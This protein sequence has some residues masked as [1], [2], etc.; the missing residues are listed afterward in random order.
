MEEEQS[1]TAA[2]CFGSRPSCL[3]SPYGVIMDSAI[4]ILFCSLRNMER[5]LFIKFSRECQEQG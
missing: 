1:K 4:Q 2:L 3:A 5:E